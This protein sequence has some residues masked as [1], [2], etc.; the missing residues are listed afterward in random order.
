MKKSKFLI[1]IWVIALIIQFALIA[2]CKAQQ[3]VPF[4]DSN[5]YWSEFYS[6]YGY[7]NYKYTYFIKGDTI[8][9]SISYHKIYSDDSTSTISY[10][11]GLREYNKRIYLFY[12]YCTHN[13]LLYNFNLTVGDSMRLSCIQPTCD[14]ATNQ[15]AKVTSIDSVLL[16]DMRY[17]KRLNFS[18]GFSSWIEG[19]GSMSGLLYPYYYCSTCMCGYESVCFKQNDTILY[20]NPDDN[21]VPCFDYITSINELNNKTD[22]ITIFPN[23]ATEQ[24][25]VNCEQPKVISIEIYN[26]LGEKNYSLSC[27]QASSTIS[28]DV[29]DFPNGVYILEE[30]T[31]KGVMVRKFVKE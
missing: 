29:S 8:L 10:I 31:K 28:I 6:N 23:P 24:I 19:I 27:R 3:Y 16:T 11:G 22:L 2:N 14:T 21:T 18:N 13:I 15:Y 30:K 4:P 1:R 9:D 12:S 25:Q 20:V 5:A 17:R 7:P 26:M